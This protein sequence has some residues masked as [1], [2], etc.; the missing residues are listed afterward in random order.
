M[1]RVKK[2]IY[3]DSCIFLALINDEPERAE[4]IAQLWDNVAADDELIIITSSSSIVEVAYSVVERRQGQ[5]DEAVERY[6][7]ELWSSPDLRF[8]EPHRV[9]MG[10]ARQLM[11]QSLHQNRSLKPMDAIHLATA[12]NMNQHGLAIEAFNTYDDRLRQYE[13]LTGLQITEPSAGQ[14]S[15]QLPDLE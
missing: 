7:D 3:W 11:R 13:L 9:I 1:S 12:M 10:Q 4:I 6:L 14:L 8:V 15:I 2:A 5:P